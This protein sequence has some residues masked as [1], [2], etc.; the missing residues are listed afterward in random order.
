MISSRKTRVV[1]TAIAVSLHVALLALFV[2]QPP[3]GGSPI[4][5]GED[6]R[7][8]VV[9]VS[10]I[11]LGHESAATTSASS[12]AAPTQTDAHTRPAPPPG[13]PLNEASKSPDAGQSAPAVSLQPNLAPE[14]TDSAVE[15]YRA[16]LEAHLARYRRYPIDARRDRIGGTVLLH[17]VLDRD[18]R[19][20]DA[21]I[22]E[23]S[24]SAA[25]D[26]EA[27]AAISR[28]QPLPAIPVGWPSRLDVTLPIA[29]DLS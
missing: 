1:S 14:M 13:P 28:A 16:A 17:F 4:A 29:F 10:L 24:G 22:A 27:L 8:T 6:D 21:W 18:G 7:Q 11:R 23:S 19:V 25:L 12:P 9:T 5:Q 15:L 2:L 26:N 3:P 20:A